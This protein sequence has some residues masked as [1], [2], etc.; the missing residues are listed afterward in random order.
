MLLSTDMTNNRIPAWAPTTLVSTLRSSEEANVAF[1]NSF[2]EEAFDLECLV[3]RRLLTHPRMRSVWA[4]LCTRRN[5]T[6]RQ[7]EQLNAEVVR[8]LLRIRNSSRRTRSEHRA[9]FEAVARTARKLARSISKDLGGKSTDAASHYEIFRLNMRLRSTSL[10]DEQRQI[11]VATVRKWLATE[12]G[13]SYG[14]VLK[15]LADT[16]DAVGKKIPPLSKPKSPTAEGQYL[17]MRLNTFFKRL[18]GE[19]LH[20]HVATIVSVATDRDFDPQ[21]VRKLCRNRPRVTQ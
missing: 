6:E 5:M 9:H 1:E 13:P 8:S 19:P 15:S 11:A 2:D 4:A 12:I 18:L 14:T 17:A 20:D 21:T 7:L 3:R 10:S 16:A